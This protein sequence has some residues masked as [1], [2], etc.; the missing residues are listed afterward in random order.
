MAR[1]PP[2]GE[3]VAQPQPERPVDLDHAEALRAGRAVQQPVDQRRR[4]G[5]S[6]AAAQPFLVVELNRLDALEVEL[7]AGALPIARRRSAV[8]LAQWVGSRRRSISWCQAAASASASVRW[9]PTTTQPPGRTTLAISSMTRDG[10]GM[11][12]RLKRVIAPS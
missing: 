11:W 4:V 5:A 12:W 2:A 6:R 3:P 10:A 1:T 9:S 7:E 8:W